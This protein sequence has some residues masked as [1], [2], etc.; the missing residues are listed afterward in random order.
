MKTIH[1]DSNPRPRKEKNKTCD[2][3]WV[4]GWARDFFFLNKNHKD[5]AKPWIILKTA[6]IL[7]SR[8]K[9]TDLFAINVI[10]QQGLEADREHYKDSRERQSTTQTNH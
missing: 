6:T 3:V 8:A 5:V 1:C 4:R 9:M 7:M 2:E 10:V